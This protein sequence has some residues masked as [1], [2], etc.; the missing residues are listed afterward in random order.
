MPSTYFTLKDAIIRVTT[1][2]RLIL[3]RLLSSRVNLGAK[4]YKGAQKMEEKCFSISL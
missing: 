1:E 3:A 4:A 2:T